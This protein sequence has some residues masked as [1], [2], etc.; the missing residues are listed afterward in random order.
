MAVGTQAPAGTPHGIG[1][2]DGHI[3][4]ASVDVVRRKDP[5]GGIGFPFHDDIFLFPGND[6]TELLD[7]ILA[8]EQVVA[9]HHI[10]MGMF[11]LTKGS[12]IDEREEIGG[13]K[14]GDPLFLSYFHPFQGFRIEGILQVPIQ[15]RATAN[16]IFELEPVI[17]PPSEDLFPCLRGIHCALEL[18]KR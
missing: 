8:V 7:Q 15:L 13:R 6:G 16:C 5:P 4:I 9:K 2:E 14:D 17:A 11:L 18:V 12:D 1:N 10:A 3:R